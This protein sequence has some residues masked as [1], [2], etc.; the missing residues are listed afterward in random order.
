MDVAWSITAKKSRLI[1]NMF[2]VNLSYIQLGQL[3]NFNNK[4][5]PKDNSAVDEI[6]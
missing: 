1:S 5:Y 3:V 4:L 2:Y 6:K